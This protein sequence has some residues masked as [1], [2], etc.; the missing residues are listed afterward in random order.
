MAW[1]RGLNARDRLANA[2]SDLNVAFRVVPDREIA[3]IAVRAVA[4]VRCDEGRHRDGVGTCRGEI[5]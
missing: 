1:S 3:F 2:K 4:F 5:R